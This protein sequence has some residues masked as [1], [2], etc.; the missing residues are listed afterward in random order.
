[1]NP[2]VHEDVDTKTFFYRRDES[3]GEAI[4]SSSEDE[5]EEEAGSVRAMSATTPAAEVQARA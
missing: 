1:M 4:G 2:H 3:V 5:D